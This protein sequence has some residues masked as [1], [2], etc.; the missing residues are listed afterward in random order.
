MESGQ[1][2]LVRHSERGEED[3]ADRKRGGKTTS[4]SGLA[5]SSPSPRGQWKTEKWRKLVVKSPVVPQQ[6]L[7]IRD[8]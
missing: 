1:N 6:P 3:K 2:Y 5:W 7:Q 4:R 8:R